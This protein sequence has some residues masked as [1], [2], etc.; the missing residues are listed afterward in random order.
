M[1]G[2]N[3]LFLCQRTTSDGCVSE[4]PATLSKVTRNLRRILTAIRNKARYS[5]RIVL[6]HYYSLNYSSS[7]ITDTVKALNGA[8]DAA[9]KGLRVQR[10]D[11]FGQYRRGSAHSGGDVCTAGLLTQL[12]SGGCGV[13]PSYAG[14]G[15]LALAV[16]RAIPH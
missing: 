6:V 3:D 7:L 14:H 16:E 11:G 1:L 5:G 2:A 9:T 12:S 10:A 4:L 13:H 8:A 15:L